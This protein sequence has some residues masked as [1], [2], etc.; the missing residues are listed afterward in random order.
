[1]DDGPGPE[2][3]YHAWTTDGVDGWTVDGTRD[4]PELLAD[5]GDLLRAELPYPRLADIECLEWGYRRN[6][7]GR[8]CERYHYAT[9]GSGPLLAAHYVNL[10]RRYR[11]PGGARSDGAWSQNAVTR[12]GHRRARHLARLGLEMF[13]EQSTAGR[14]FVVGVTNEES[15]AAV[16][17]HMGFRRV[18]PLPVTVVASVG[19]GRRRIEHFEVTEEWLGSDRFDDFASMIDRHPVTGWATEWSPEVMR[20]R[21]AR[22]HTRYRVHV[23]DD[24]AVVTTRTSWGPLPATVVLKLLP[25]TRIG[26][27]IDATRTI[28]SIARNQRSVF[29]VHAGFNGSVTVRGVR[30]P[31]RLQPSPLDLVVRRL[32]PDVD[33]DGLELD[34]FEL[35]DTDAY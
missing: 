20:W 30:A 34:T 13:E 15:T 11:G 22:P 24:V 4:D 1:M 29:A 14:S 5:A 32:D 12:R 27:P 18:G 25:L 2:V 23:G 28:R 10:P 9:A 26:L 35:L 19:R 17:S 3:P 33:Q 7:A 21:L 31:R 16:V 8:A 6:P